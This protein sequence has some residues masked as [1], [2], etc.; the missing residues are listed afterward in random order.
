[1]S[2]PSLGDIQGQDGWDPKQS[3]I[4]VGSTAHGRELEP[5]N[6]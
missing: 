3:N 1:M 6:L 4:V 2:A 5:D